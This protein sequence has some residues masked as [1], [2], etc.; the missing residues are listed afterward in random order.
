M[1][2]FRKGIEAPIVV[3]DYKCCPAKTFS[4]ENGNTVP[5]R[6]VF[7]HC[8]IVGSVAKEIIKRMFGNLGSLLFPIGSE[9][10]AASHDI[11]K[12][13]PTFY[14]KIMRACSLE[15]IPGVNPDLER[16]W[17]G[18]TGV[19][20]LTARLL[21]APEYVPEI[22]GQHHGFSPNVAGMRADDT[23]FGGESW[24]RE[25]EKLV[26][27]L[28]DSLGAT[29]PHVESL[30]QA[31]VLAGL[32]SVADWIGSGHHF[33]DPQVSWQDKVSEAL[34][35]AGFVAASF[36]S[37]LK[38]QDVFGFPPRPAQ[39]VLIEHV[40]RPGVYVLEAPMGM[41]KTE[42]SL[43]AAYNMLVSGQARGVYFALPTQLT[44]NKVFERFQRYLDKILEDGCQHRSLLLHANAW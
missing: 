32:T 24:Q 38:F 16:E 20:Q 28:Q 25:R 37:D 43:Y 13:S 12:V 10:A 41:G 27:A 6:T 14:N 44:S 36:R 11:G 40:S 8:Q 19:S 26:N 1:P 9:I 15:Q 5:G 35:E 31:R 18:H 22:L 39:S 29:W 4:Q 34:N 30:A 7:S 33:D 3:V 23:K 17:G 21:K 2:I 42:A